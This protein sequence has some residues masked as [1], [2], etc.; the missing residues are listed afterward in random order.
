ME[1]NELEDASPDHPFIDLTGEAPQHFEFD[2]VESELVVHPVKNILNKLQEAQA[3]SELPE[4]LSAE[5]LGVTSPNIEMKDVEAFDKHF[6]INQW[7]LKPF[8]VHTALQGQGVYLPE[9]IKKL[10]SGETASYNRGYADQDGG[11]SIGITKDVFHNDIASHGIENYMV[12]KRLNLAGETPESIAA[13][14]TILPGEMRVH[15]WCDLQGEPHVIP[16]A[17]FDKRVADKNGHVAFGYS[18]SA[19]RAAE[20]AAY[21]AIK[22]LPLEDRTGCFFG[23]DIVLLKDGSYKPVELNPTYVRGQ[24]PAEG[25]EEGPPQSSG[26]QGYPTALAAIIAFVRGKLPFHAQFAKEHLEALAPK[27]EWPQAT[28]ED[29]ALS[30]AQF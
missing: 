12:Q 15:V 7:V 22:A 3:S 14:D 30:G 21:K 24:L 4:T 26:Y 20:E 5:Q 13:G 16:Y 23:P 10:L 25:G 27:K 17:T 11:D 28:E 18:T 9:N 29:L 8:D 19:T 1:E 6:G 2:P